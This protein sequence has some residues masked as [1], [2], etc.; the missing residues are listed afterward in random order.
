MRAVLFITVL[1]V[2]VAI[3]MTIRFHTGSVYDDLAKCEVVKVEALERLVRCANNI[4]RLITDQ[5]ECMNILKFI[6]SIG[7]DI[8]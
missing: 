7:G 4:V 2:G 6:S 3:G 1:A 5:E 8:P